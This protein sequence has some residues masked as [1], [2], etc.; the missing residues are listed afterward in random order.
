MCQ[1]IADA[2]VALDKPYAI[3]WAGA[4]SQ[5][6]QL[7]LQLRYTEHGGT[8]ICEGD[9]LTRETVQDMHWACRDILVGLASSKGQGQRYY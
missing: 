4:R 1:H 6:T 9:T 5:I 3:D 8:K 2:G 7:S